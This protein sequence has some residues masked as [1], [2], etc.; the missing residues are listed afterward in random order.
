MSLGPSFYFG[1]RALLHKEPRAASVR[2]SSPLL[3]LF[4]SSAEFER[5]LGSLA[6]LIDSARRVREAV[7]AAKMGELEAHGLGSAS[8]RAFALEGVLPCSEPLAAFE[9]MYLVRHYQTGKLYTLRQQLKSG[10][11]DVGVRARLPR[12]LEILASLSSAGCSEMRPSYDG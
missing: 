10:L 1:E 3:L 4:I 8:R 5:K 12:E 9:R 2:A 11:L 7:A 6:L